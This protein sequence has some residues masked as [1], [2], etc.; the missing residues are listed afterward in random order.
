MFQLRFKI[1]STMKTK[2]KKRYTTPITNK[3]LVQMEDCFC[4]SITT[5]SGKG[6]SI[7]SATQDYEEVDGASGFES[8]NG[9]ISWE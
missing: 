3:S 1:I 6:A 8:S 9:S 4:G 2:T 7:K 5:D